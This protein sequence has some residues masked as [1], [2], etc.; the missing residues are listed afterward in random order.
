MGGLSQLQLER[1]QQVDVQ[2]RDLD[3]QSALG[4]AGSRH[5]L[6]DDNGGGYGWSIGSA[7]TSSPA[8]MDLLTVVMHELGHILGEIRK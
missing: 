4:L 2:I 7:A 1:L 5:V 8:G 3:A 6:I